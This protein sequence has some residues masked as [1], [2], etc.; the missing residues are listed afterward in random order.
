MHRLVHF[1][2][3]FFFFF[4]LSLTVKNFYCDVEECQIKHVPFSHFL[5]HN[6]FIYLFIQELQSDKLAAQCPVIGLFSSD[7]RR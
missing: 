4:F 3:S 5:S 6:L 1:F 7:A 2:L